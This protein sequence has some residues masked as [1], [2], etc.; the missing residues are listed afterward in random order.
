MLRRIG[1]LT[2]VVAL[3]LAAGCA[4]GSPAAEPSGPAT[5][6]PSAPVVTTPT[7]PDGGSGPPPTWSVTPP[8]TLGRPSGP[9]KTPSDPY[10]V[11]TFVGR[12]VRGGNGPCYGVETDEG[13]VYAVYSTRAGALAAGTTVRVHLAQSRPAA[14][15]GPGR[16][17]GATRIETIG[18]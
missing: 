17:V 1:L 12:V 18:Y 11:N 2:G 13:T 8:P 9:P 4:G 7:P 15:C 6:G 10:P 3:G 5:S 16:P 14:D